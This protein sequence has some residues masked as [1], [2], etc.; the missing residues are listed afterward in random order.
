MY[1]DQVSNRKKG[2]REKAKE[3]GRKAEKDKDM[4]SKRVI[5]I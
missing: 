5:K 1:Y 3:T 4:E 2:R